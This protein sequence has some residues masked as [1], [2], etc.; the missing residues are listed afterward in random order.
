V[1]YEQFHVSYGEAVAIA[2]YMTVQRRSDQL[3]FR[4]ADGTFTARTGGDSPVPYR[5]PLTNTGGDSY[6]LTVPPAE[7]LPALTGGDVYLVNY[8]NQLTDPA[9][10]GDDLILS[11][12]VGWNGEAVTEPADAAGDYIDDNDLGT[13]LGEYNLTLY[14][15]TDGDSARDVGAVQQAIDDAESDINL[16]AG[17]GPALTP[18]AFAGGTAAQQAAARKTVEKWAKWLAAYYVAAKRGLSGVEM[19]RFKALRDAAI[20]EIG[21]LREGTLNLP[22]LTADPDDVPDQAG[23]WVAVE[24][25]RADLVSTTGDEFSDE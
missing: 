2:V 25:V 20:Q 16:Y 21:W 17:G 19:E 23:E 5:M 14:A 10:D 7:D 3:W 4:P 13:F 22:G 18:L 1:G 9:T 15:D 12:D 11:E 6:V 8:Y 24:V